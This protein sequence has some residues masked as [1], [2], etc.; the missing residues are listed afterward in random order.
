MGF[1]LRW[2]GILL[3]AVSLFSLAQKLYEFATAPVVGDLLPYY[4][5]SLHPLVSV[6]SEALA[7]GSRR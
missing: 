2:L 6:F 1:C 5:E 7:R 3:G 4:R